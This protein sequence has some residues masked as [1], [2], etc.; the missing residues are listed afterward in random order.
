MSALDVVE[1]EDEPWRSLEDLGEAGALTA[2]VIS[3]SAFGGRAGFGS[4]DGSSF[5]GIGGSEPSRS[6]AALCQRAQ[7]RQGQYQRTDDELVERHED[8]QLVLWRPA[9]RF[10]QLCQLYD[11]SGYQSG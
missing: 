7:G 10:L 11:A 2:S 8:S 4:S 6:A 9:F 5:I 3:T 1:A